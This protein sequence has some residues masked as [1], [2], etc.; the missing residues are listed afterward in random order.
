MQVAL[1]VFLAKGQQSMSDQN[2]PEKGKTTVHID[3]LLHVVDR[4]ETDVH[5]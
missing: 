1:L 4:P 3:S 5:V 2:Y